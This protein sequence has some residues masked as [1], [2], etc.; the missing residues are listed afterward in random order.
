VTKGLLYIIPADPKE[1]RE[2][3][4]PCPQP[5]GWQRSR[6]RKL[7]PKPQKLNPRRLTDLAGRPLWRPLLGEVPAEVLAFIE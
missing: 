3:R 5:R 1:I 7:L 4:G 6:R 2:Q